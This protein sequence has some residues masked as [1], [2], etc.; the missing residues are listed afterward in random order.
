M[1][2]P[3]MPTLKPM[4]RDD[5]DTLVDRV[6]IKLAYCHHVDLTTDETARQVIDLIQSYIPA[7]PSSAAPGS[8]PDAMSINLAWNIWWRD[9]S[10]KGDPARNGNI[11]QDAFVDGYKRGW[12]A[13]RPSAAQPT[14]EA[15]VEWVAG[16]I[17]ERDYTDERYEAARAIIRRVRSHAAPS[18]QQVREDASA[19]CG[20]IFDIIDAN[21]GHDRDDAAVKVTDLLAR[22]MSAR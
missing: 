21:P 7:R 12:Q 6:A 17:H 22:K 8:E 1:S 18:P 9:Q 11:A 19:L 15:L 3:E 4:H 13:S 20:E 10:R 14:D 2:A 16:E 5:A